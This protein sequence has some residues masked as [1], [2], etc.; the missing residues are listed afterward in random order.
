MSEQAKKECKRTTVEN[1]YSSKVTRDLNE[2]FLLGISGLCA[3]RG[4]GVRIEHDNIFIH[5]PET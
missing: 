3:P 4:A 5:G 2:R 1:V